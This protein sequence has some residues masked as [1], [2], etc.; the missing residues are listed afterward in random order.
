VGIAEGHAVTFAAGLA[1]KGLRPVVAIYS[2]FLQRSYDQIMQDVA[3]DGI[4]VI[5]CIDRAGLVGGDGPTHHGN[6]DLSYL[7]TVPNAVIM[8]PK[9][10]KELRDMLFTAVGYGGGPVFIRYPRGNGPGSDCEAEF[11]KIEI[12]IPQVISDAD[13]G[14]DGQ[15]LSNKKVALI[16]I[17]DMLGDALKV[18]GLLA[19]QGVG[20]EVVNARFAKPLDADFYAGIFSKYPI[21]AT[22]ENNTL[23]GGFGSSLLA[24]ASQQDN[25]ERPPKFLRFG[26]PDKFIQ[27]GNVR[28]LKE[29]LGL[30]PEVMAEKILRAQPL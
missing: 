9:D 13:V 29:E 26:L 11:E 16:S 2:S 23:S 6:F 12:G 7:N 17:G 25:L 3:L 28:K 8:A 4:S 20:A 1:L 18:R 5:F 30:V 19:A 22:F 24:L 15:L 21:V 10:E 27:H 14:Q